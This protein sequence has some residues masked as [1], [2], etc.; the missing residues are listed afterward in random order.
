M[1]SA[2]LKV[3]RLQEISRAIVKSSNTGKAPSIKDIITWTEYNIGLTKE[4]AL[5]YIHIVIKAHPSWRI[6]KEHIHIKEA[7]K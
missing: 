3:E 2:S 7:E 5:E 6:E 4:K 1:D